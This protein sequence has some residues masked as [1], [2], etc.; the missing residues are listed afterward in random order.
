MF[1]IIAFLSD[2]PY[3]FAALIEQITGADMSAVTDLFSGGFANIIEIAEKL[4]GA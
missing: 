1:S 4:L 3:Y 2:I